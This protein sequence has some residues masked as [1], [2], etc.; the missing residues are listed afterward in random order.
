MEEKFPSFEAFIEGE[1]KKVRGAKRLI[2]ALYIFVCVKTM[3]DNLGCIGQ[4]VLFV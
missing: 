4:S 1:K 2:T 3:L